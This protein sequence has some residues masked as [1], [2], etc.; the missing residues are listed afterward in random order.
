MPAPDTPVEELINIGPKSALWLREIGIES[1]ADL[2][3]AGPVLTYKILQHRFK[4]INILMLYALYATTL[5][6]HWNALTPD[7]KEMLKKAARE[8]LDIS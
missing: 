4:G 6:R 3:K 5:D 8:P 1:Y 2:E 7:E